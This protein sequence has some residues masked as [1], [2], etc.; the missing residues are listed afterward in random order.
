MILLVK[1]ESFR[2]FS[3]SLEV[4]R[5]KT[6]SC[7]FIKLGLKLDP[8]KTEGVKEGR[9]T[10]HQNYQKDF[11][12]IQSAKFKTCLPMMAIVAPAQNANTP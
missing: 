6:V 4:E 1:K 3:H 12:T 11:F 5:N 2:N 9:E 8:V 7:S 10:L